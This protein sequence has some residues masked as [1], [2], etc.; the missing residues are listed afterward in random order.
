MKRGK[1]Q[2]RTPG[3][4][5]KVMAPERDTCA[6]CG[7]RFTADSWIQC[8]HVKHP[9]HAW[10]VARFDVS[11][12]ATKVHKECHDICH[13]MDDSEEKMGPHMVRKT[14]MDIFDDYYVVEDM[15]DKAGL[16]DVRGD[17]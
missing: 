15:L 8:H 12:R 7:E 9:R 1:Y 13:S 5:D 10:L 3:Y 14:L 17:V 16:I 2:T 4:E 6:Y 11:L